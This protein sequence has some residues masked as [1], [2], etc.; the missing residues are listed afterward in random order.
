MKFY[1]LLSLTFTIANT[2]IFDRYDL[3]K[4][5]FDSGMTNISQWICIINRLSQ[6]NTAYHISVSNEKSGHGLFTIYHPFWC[7]IG[8]DGGKCNINCEK[9]RDD[10]ITDDIECVNVILERQGIGAWG[11]S[12]ESC[13][14]DANI[15]I[16]DWVWASQQETD[17][18]KVCPPNRF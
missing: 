3:A 10:D 8:E 17:S 11:R 13:K 12:E 1:L 5:L 7:G 15:D 16:P 14:R 4:T 6:F 9:F 2:K 18:G